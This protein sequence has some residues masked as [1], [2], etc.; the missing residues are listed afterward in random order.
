MIRVA[1]LSPL[2]IAAAPMS[3][4]MQRCGGDPSCIASVKKFENSPEGVKLMKQQRLDEAAAAKDYS[5]RHSTTHVVTRYVN[6]R[7]VTVTCTIFQD[8]ADSVTVCK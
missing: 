8:G 5:D 7:K 2:L 6:G 1:L 3:A 4:P